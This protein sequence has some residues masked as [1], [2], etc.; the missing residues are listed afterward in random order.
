[1]FDGNDNYMNATFTLPQPFTI[2]GLVNTVTWTGND[3]LIQGSA[4]F[5]RQATSSPQVFFS[6]GTEI[7][8]ISPTLNTVNVITVVGNGAS[9]LIKLNNNAAVT[10]NANTG[11]FTNPYLCSTPPVVSAFANTD[12][13][14]WVFFGAA[15]DD[16][17]MARVIR[18]LQRVGGLV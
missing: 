9:S 2:Y 17:A 3:R 4:A 14:E 12:N 5:I 15:H 13:Y 11:A 16:A 8:P 18:Y 1:L 10:G 7:G 6:A